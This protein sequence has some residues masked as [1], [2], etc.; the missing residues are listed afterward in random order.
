V[1]RVE[2]PEEALASPPEEYDLLQITRSRSPFRRLGK[3][4][5]RARPGRDAEGLNLNRRHT[6]GYALPNTTQW[7]GN[8]VFVQLRTPR[9]SD[10]KPDCL[11]YQ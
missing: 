9:C 6:H 3:R 8:C 5:P 7:H 10:P 4:P 1:F 11:V 2:E